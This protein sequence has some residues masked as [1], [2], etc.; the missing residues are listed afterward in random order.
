L[1]PGIAKRETG[2]YAGRMKLTLVV[3]AAG[4]GSRFGGLKQ[5]QPVGPGDELILDYSVFDA[6]RAGFERLALVIRPEHE[7]AFRGSIGGRLARQIE[8]VYC[9]QRLDD[10]PAGA[11]PPEGRSK[12][13]GTGHAT[14]AAREAVD[15]PFAVI[16]ADDFYGAASFAALGRFL[17]SS[18]GQVD[19]A[20]VGFR[21]DQTLSE[22]GTVSRGVCRVSED[23]WLQ[24][25][26][27]RT[28]I[29]RTDA[30]ISYAGEDGQNHRLS[31]AEMVSMNFWGFPASFMTSLA[32]QWEAF[33][34]ARGNDAKAEFYLP[35]A[36]DEQARR[37][38]LRIRALNTPS[39]W[40]GITY[41]EDLASAREAIR[42]RIA[43]GDYPERLWA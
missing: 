7:E 27:E 2:G 32:D 31:G 29:Q 8:T 13:W 11:V 43:A 19:G 22:H 41:R 24:A 39:A 37:G 1:A 21:L 17:Q 34:A 40:F 4:M 6:R 23:G 18:D 10:L 25:I 16:N 30:G 3:L 33:V 38:A 9:H 20:L 26:E 12:P 15:G 14:L 5:I 36:V 42:Q 35:F 28:A